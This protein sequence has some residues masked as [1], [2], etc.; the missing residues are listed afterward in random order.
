MGDHEHTIQ[1][2]SRNLQVPWAP[3]ADVTTIDRIDGVCHDKC[4]ECIADLTVTIAGNIET[5][6]V[7]IKRSLG[8]LLLHQETPN[9][10]WLEGRLHPCDPLPTVVARIQRMGSNA[11]N[12]SLIGMLRTFSPEERLA[13]AAASINLAEQFFEQLRLRFLEERRRKSQQNPW[14]QTK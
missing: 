3:H 2:W 8:L 4:K 6:A 10:T 7:V 11:T 5:L 13:I 9:F 12:S 14:W 1:F